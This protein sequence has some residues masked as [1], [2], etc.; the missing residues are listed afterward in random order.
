MRR[1]CD[2]DDPFTHAF[3]IGSSH[4]GLH[5]DSTVKQEANKSFDKNAVTQFSF[6]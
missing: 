1:G 2:G 3:G 5:L 4:L 6:H